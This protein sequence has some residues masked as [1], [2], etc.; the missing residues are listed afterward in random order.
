MDSKTSFYCLED[1]AENVIEA[2]LDTGIV[3]TNLR[4][5]VLGIA[6]NSKQWIVS[7]V[8]SRYLKEQFKHKLTYRCSSE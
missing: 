3:S 6:Q 7:D 1:K 2:V 5:L 8:S 4:D